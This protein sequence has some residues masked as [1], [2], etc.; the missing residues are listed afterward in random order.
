MSAAGT[1]PGDLDC[2]LEL[3]W[4]IIQIELRSVQL[5]GRAGLQND[6]SAA[7]VGTVPPV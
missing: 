1:K 5:N 6:N 4:F 2:D 3:Q 7:R